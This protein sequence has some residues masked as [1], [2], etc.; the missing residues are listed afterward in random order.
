MSVCLCV[1]RNAA[2]QQEERR[3]RPFNVGGLAEQSNGPPPPPTQTE[4]EYSFLY[5][6]RLTAIR[7]VL[8]TSSLTL[9]KQKFYFTTEL[10]RL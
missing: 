8:A 4:I 5:Y 1:P 2:R 3:N 10:L 7:F 6:W 9:K